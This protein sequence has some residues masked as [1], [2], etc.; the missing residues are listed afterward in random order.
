MEDELF[1]NSTAKLYVGAITF[2]DRLN[3]ALKVRLG[4]FFN[5]EQLVTDEVDNEREEFAKKKI[6]NMYK[7]T[8]D[9]HAIHTAVMDSLSFL[10]EEQKQMEF[11]LSILEDAQQRRGKKIDGKV[12]KVLLRYE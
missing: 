5:Q 12:M 11:I 10:E 6:A 2:A 8:D 1:E 9:P 4:I 7:E 3:R